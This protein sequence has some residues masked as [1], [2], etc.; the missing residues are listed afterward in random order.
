MV[1]HLYMVSLG[2]EPGFVSVYALRAL[3]I[4]DVVY[5][6]EYTSFP[7]RGSI[8]DIESMVGKRFRRLYRRDLEDDDGRLIFSDLER[9]LSVCFV[10]WGD[11][12]MA[13][14]HVSI[15]RRA[16][17]RG[18][19]YTYIPGVSI[20]SAALGVCGLMVYRLGKIATITRPWEGVLSEHPYNVLKDNMARDLH[21]LFLLEIDVDS[22]YYM[23]ASEAVDILFRIERSRGEGVVRG[24]LEAIVLAGIGAGGKI[25]FTT[26][27][28]IEDLDDIADLYPHSLIIPSS[29]YFTER[30][31]LE[32]FSSRFGPCWTLSTGGL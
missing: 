16:V 14:T 25:C 15:A 20:V 9:G 12:L 23:S 31:F 5:F 11:C 32:A 18:Y 30:E 10:C 7:S 24:D 13:T 6:E 22:G 21:T 2:L 4:C 19:G 27:D 3:K 28:S 1:G 29:L 8:A 17:E 26:L